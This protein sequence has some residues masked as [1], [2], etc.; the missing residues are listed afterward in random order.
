MLARELMWLRAVMGEE[1]SDVSHCGMRCSH[2]GIRS[3]HGGR[4]CVGMG[5]PPLCREG[6]V[7]ARHEWI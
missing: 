5:G 1:L 2:T 3:F 6:E 7:V 4:R